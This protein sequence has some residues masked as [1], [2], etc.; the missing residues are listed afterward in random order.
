LVG[1]YVSQGLDH[2][3]IAV[4]PKGK[5]D[6]LWVTWSNGNA[7]YVDNSVVGANGVLTDTAGNN[8]GFTKTPIS[9]NTNGIDPYLPQISIGTDGR[10]AVTYEQENTPNNSKL[11]VQTNTNG[12]LIKDDFKTMGSSVGANVG[13]VPMTQPIP[14]AN[15]SPVATTFLGSGDAP[16]E[17]GNL[18][19]ALGAR[20]FSLQSSSYPLESF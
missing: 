5:P 8:H 11:Y 7:L 3:A 19:S 20:G 9:L 2:P 10:V 14:V 16:G 1:T 4:T 12:T 15:A 6:A 13:T 18:P 17:N